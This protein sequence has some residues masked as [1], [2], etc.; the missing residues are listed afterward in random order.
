MSQVVRITGLVII[1]GVCLVSTATAGMFGEAALAIGGTWP[2]GEFTRYADAGFIVSGRVTGHI[3]H[4]ELVSGWVG[5]S[6]AQ[7]SED[8]RNTTAYIPGGPSVPVD[9]TTSESAISGFIGIQLSSMTRRAFFRPRAA[10]GLGIYGFTTT[11]TWTFE[12]QDTTIEL[13]SRRDDSQTCLGWRGM[14]GAD[15]FVTTTIGISADFIYDHVL[16]LNQTET[17]LQEDQ[18]NLTS[19]FHGFS[20]GVVYMFSS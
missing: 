3:P 1:L 6:F 18:A 15:F 13:D 19:R 16:G 11:T 5:F 14:I 7:F 20:V 12:T 8:T 17:P 4:F 9:Q 10:V 2:Q